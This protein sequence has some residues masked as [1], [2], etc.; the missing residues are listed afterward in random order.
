[1]SLGLNILL[2]KLIGD[3]SRDSTQDRVFPKNSVYSPV[4]LFG[5]LIRFLMIKSEDS[6][7]DGVATV[8]ALEISTADPVLVILS[9]STTMVPRDPNNGNSRQAASHYFF[10]QPIIEFLQAKTS[11]AGNWPLVASNY[12]V[13]WFDHM[14][15][16]SNE[17]PRIHFISPVYSRGRL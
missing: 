17:S 3:N 2:S 4:F 8:T 14:P 7:L 5:I 11:P 12:V 13:L 6:T 10:V 1:M 9:V 15:N 16:L